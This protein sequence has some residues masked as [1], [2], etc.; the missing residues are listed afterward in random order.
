MRRLTEP[1]EDRETN[2]KRIWKFGRRNSVH[3]NM[4]IFT[5]NHLRRHSLKV[6]PSDRERLPFPWKILKQ[7]LLEQRIVELSIKG[8]MFVMLYLFFLF[9]VYFDTEFLATGGN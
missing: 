5:Q 6:I 4:S 9:T 1:T 2:H 8:W 3:K 7:L